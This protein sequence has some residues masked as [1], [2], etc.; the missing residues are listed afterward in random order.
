MKTL[1]S[2]KQFAKHIMLEADK[3]DDYVH[4]GYGKYKEKDPSTGEAKADSP[5]YSKDD[6]GNFTA[7]DDKKGDKKGGEKGDKKVPDTQKISGAGEFERPKATK[8]DVD[9]DMYAQDTWDRQSGDKPIQT[10]DTTM[11]D[12]VLGK[13]QMADKP[14]YEDWEVDDVILD[15]EDAGD[16]GPYIKALKSAK[17]NSSK[18]HNILIKAKEKSTKSVT[19]IDNDKGVK[20]MAASIEK[21]T[22]VSPGSLELQGRTKANDG[23]LIIQW[24]DK[25]DGTLMGISDDG[26]VYED[27]KK[28]SYKADQ[29]S[30]SVKKR[31]LGGREAEAAYHKADMMMKKYAGV[32]I[33]KAAYWA[34]EKKKAADA[35]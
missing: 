15:L 24:K 5:V 8:Q 27:G 18:I 34:K 6:S 2:Y 13:P 20:R 23:T 33:K 3:S 1:S 9:S 29:D 12:D 4:I 35:M 30:S 7:T 14:E 25:S 19:P 21:K 31:P 28:T 17:G 11:L 26:S 32:D 22:N 16:Y 10:L